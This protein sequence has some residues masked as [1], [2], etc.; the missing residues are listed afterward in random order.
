MFWTSVNVVSSVYKALDLALASD[1]HLQRVCVGQRQ[2][3][4]VCVCVCVCV[5]GYGGSS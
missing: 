2:N 1:F 4:R 5:C 3:R